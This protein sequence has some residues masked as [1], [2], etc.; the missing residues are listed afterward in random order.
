MRDDILDELPTETV[1]EGVRDLET[2][3]AVY[4]LEDLD[5]EDQEEILEALPPTDRVALQ[6]ASIIPKVPPAGRCRPTLVAVPPFW[7]AGADARPHA[8]LNAELPDSF[9]EIF[10]VDPGHRLLGHV[11]LDRLVRTAGRAVDRASWRP[12]AA[13]FLLDDGPGGRGP[14]CSSGTI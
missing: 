6:R 5:K 8:R 1:V 11:F 12:I 14:R 3:D 2:D 4:I 7:T 10:V 9:F 13:A